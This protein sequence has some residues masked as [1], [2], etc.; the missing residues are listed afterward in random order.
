MKFRQ[1]PAAIV[2]AT[3][4]ALPFASCN[5]PSYRSQPYYSQGAAPQPPGS[6]GCGS[7]SAPAPEA[8]RPGSRLAKAEPL[9]PR[10][11][12][13]HPSPRPAPSAGT[14]PYPLDTCLVT[15]G[16]LGSMGAP[17]VINYK[18]QEIKFCCD[19]CE[20]KFRKDPGKYL[21]K[22]KSR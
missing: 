2:A 17:H 6:C 20:P 14:K 9:Q 13:G 7:S 8:P 3:L 21:A 22:L 5:V 15:G 10:P 11:S 1:K 12:A 4:A 18:G 19:H 16:K